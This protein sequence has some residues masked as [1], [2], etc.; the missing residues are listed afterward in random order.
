MWSIEKETKVLVV[1]LGR[2]GVAA[3]R[4]LSKMD[5]DVR[6]TDMKPLD[7]LV[8][9][10]GPSE[11]LAD[12]II[13]GS[14]PVEAFLDSD[15]IVLSPGVPSEIEPLQA[16]R[17][18][19][20]PIIGE[21]ELASRYIASPLCAVTGT[22][23]KTTTVVL[24]GRIL[25]AAGIDH[26]VC[27][28]VGTPLVEY[29]D[30]ARADAIGIVE[31]SS[32][33][34]ETIDT[35]HPRISMIINITEDHLDR[36]TGMEEYAAAKGRI[37][38]NQT[39]ADDAVLN[40][41]DPVILPKG[42]TLAATPCWF[43]RRKPV[44]RGVSRHHDKLRWINDME[45]ECYPLDV[46]KLK[47]EHNLENVMAAVCAAKLL[48]ADRDAIIEALGA[49]RGLAHRIEF[50]GGV[51]GVD[52]Y[53]DS[54]GTNIGAVQRAIDTLCDRPILLIAGGLDKE[55]NFGALRPFIRE[56]VRGLV[57]MGECR[58][59]IRRILGDEADTV[60]VD[61]IEEAV[62]TAFDMAS[63]GDAVLLSPGCASFDMFESYTERGDRFR[64]AVKELRN[65]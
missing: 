11:D 28:N 24:I 14:H 4:F 31:V 43:S 13:A 48:G 45:E 54:K 59:R 5:V 39:P 33:Q 53:N 18:Q 51:D 21:I 17:E 52:F 26:F 47:G 57:L 30:D 62:A 60:I 25:E 10:L 63:P 41:D 61:S 23:G 34:L 42:R 44:S 7:A 12:R 56:H 40:A 1:G 20:I 16:A 38:S 46:I 50:C 6:G 49:F 27:G 35:F 58:E 36:Y 29:A 2:S 37:I 3:L 64:A 8:P 22:N 65:E 9:L 55:A 32:F 15:L 19:S